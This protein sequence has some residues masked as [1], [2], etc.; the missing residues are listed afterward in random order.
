L[1]LDE[2]FLKTL[3]QGHVLIDAAHSTLHLGQ[4][5]LPFGMKLP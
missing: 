3:P 4:V 1:F 5:F 2:D